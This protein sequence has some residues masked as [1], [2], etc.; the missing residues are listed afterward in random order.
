MWVDPFLQNDL[1]KEKVKQASEQ[2]EP[3]Q[4][5]SFTSKR[6]EQDVQ[7]L[8]QVRFWI[9][10]KPPGCFTI[11]SDVRRIITDLMEDTT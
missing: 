7:L 2:K 3:H 5:R 10:S 1:Q 4:F 8:A 6:A 11:P 9:G